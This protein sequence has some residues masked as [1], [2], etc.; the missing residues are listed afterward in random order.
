MQSDKN[1]NYINRVFDGAIDLGYDLFHYQNYSVTS[2]IA[3]T[4]QTDPDIG[5]SAEIRMIGDGTHT[6]VF[7][8][9]FTKSA[10]SADYDST[11]NAINKIVFYFDGYSAF[12]SITVL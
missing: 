7:D 3:V 9:A 12:Y 2:N 4:L 8:V 10:G 5:G 11:L 6:P 1:G